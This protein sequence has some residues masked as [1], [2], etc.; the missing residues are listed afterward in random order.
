MARAYLKI[1]VRPG[2][3]RAVKEALLKIKGMKSVDLT[4]GDQDIIALVEASSYD[5]ILNLV[6]NNLRIIDGI[7]KTITNLVVG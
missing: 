3:E 5:D 2:G 4:A 6:L 1:N 7:E